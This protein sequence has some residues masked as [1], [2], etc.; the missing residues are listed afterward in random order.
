V[1]RSRGRRRLFRIAAVGLSL[2]ISLAVVE[3]GT[4]ARYRREYARHVA[5]W[6]HPLLAL[7]PDSPLE[8]VIRPKVQHATW[9]ARAG[10]APWSYTIN[11]RG[12]RGPDPGPKSKGTM[13][14]I[15]LGDSYTFGWGLNDDQTFPHYLGQLTSD[16]GREIEVIN[17]GVP[18]YNTAQEAHYLNTQWDLEPDLVILTYVPNDDEPHFNV[19]P[20]PPEKRFGGDLWIWA[21]ASAEMRRAVSSTKQRSTYLDSFDESS[22]RWRAS[23]AALADIGRACKKHNV[24]LLVAIVP[25]FSSPFTSK[26]PYAAIHRSVTDWCAELDI[27]VIDLFGVFSGKDHK[28]YHLKNDGHPNPEANKL[29]AR[30][31]RNAIVFDG[32]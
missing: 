27:E 28:Q 16:G 30:T 2:A 21:K 14:I 22:K 24:A 25:D 29:I 17:C 8:F 23:K 4:R 15:A 9:K 31:L 19:V 6:S 10:K 32:G 18:G 20:T 11:S 3:I 26:Y 5:K 12:C 1:N 13:R 7:E